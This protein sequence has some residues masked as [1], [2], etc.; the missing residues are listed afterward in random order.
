MILH[1]KKELG[2]E[3]PAPDRSIRA[4]GIVDSCPF[5]NKTNT[6]S[7]L[8]TPFLRVCE[9]VPWASSPPFHARINA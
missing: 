6:S 1:M 2:M 8:L 5:Q 3:E 4:Q 7:F 9:K